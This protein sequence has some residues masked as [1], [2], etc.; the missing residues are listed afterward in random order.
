MPLPEFLAGRYRQYKE[1]TSIFTTWLHR[2]AETCG[3]KHPATGQQTGNAA[4]P[5]PDAV[6]NTPSKRLKGKERKLAKLAGENVSK[7][8]PKVTEPV[9]KTVKYRVTTSEL[10]RQAN[11]IAESTSKRV[12]MPDG[13]RSILN[14]AISARQRCAEWY[15]RVGMPNRSDQGH[16]YFID[17]MQTIL[18]LLSWNVSDTK[19]DKPNSKTSLRQQ[20]NLEQLRYVLARSYVKVVVASG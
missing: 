13:I 15:A 11:A 17:T 3:Y 10:L 4:K 8:P 9:I 6:I 7:Q 12:I 18:E 20:K 14:R 5:S 2:A 1:D 16:I 19:A